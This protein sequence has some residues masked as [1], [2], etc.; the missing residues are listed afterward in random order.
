MRPQAKVSDAKARMGRITR[1]DL[2][3]LFIGDLLSFFSEQSP[4]N[5]EVH[6]VGII[7]ATVGEGKCL[8]MGDGSESKIDKQTECNTSFLL[9]AEGARRCTLCYGLPEVVS[10]SSVG[11]RDTRLVVK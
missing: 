9:V 7:A 8:P 10:P 11:Q 1:K 6:L 5:W 4:T 3:C 2:M